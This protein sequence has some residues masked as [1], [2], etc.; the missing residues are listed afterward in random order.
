MKQLQGFIDRNNPT[1]ICKLHKALW[2][3]TSVTSVV[4]K[5][6]QVP[7]LFWQIQQSRSIP[8]SLSHS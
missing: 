4:P 2:P 1:H 3:Q 6:H 8:T 5:A 7:H